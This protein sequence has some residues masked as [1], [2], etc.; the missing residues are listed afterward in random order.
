MKSKVIIVG[1]GIG[2]KDN[3]TVKVKKALENADVIVYDRL[4]NHDIIREY[5]G[6]KELY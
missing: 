6:K 2:D 1:A 4:I 5:E 3:I